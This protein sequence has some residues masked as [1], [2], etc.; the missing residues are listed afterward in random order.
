MII[1]KNSFESFIRISSEKKI[2]AFGA[3]AA[4]TIVAIIQYKNNLINVGDLFIIILLYELFTFTY[5]NA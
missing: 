4:G 3:S 5:F 1:E 2:V